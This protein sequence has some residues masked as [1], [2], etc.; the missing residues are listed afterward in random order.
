MNRT[1]KNSEPLDIRYI[2]G[3]IDGEGCISITKTKKR[4]AGG[5][6]RY[7]PY[8]AITHTNLEI[9]ERLRSIYP[10]GRK[11]S[12]RPLVTG[13]RQCYSIRWDGNE[14]RRLL[15]DLVPHLQEK[16]RQAELVLEFMKTLRCKHEH[17]KAIPEFILVLREDYYQI[18]K[19]LKK[20]PTEANLPIMEATRLSKEK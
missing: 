20:D 1:T 15:A 10:I 13:R 14:L 12:S 16:R 5:A 18:L 9:L 11:I 4:M 19:Y 8:L 6:P 7:F 2:A 3:F 17:R